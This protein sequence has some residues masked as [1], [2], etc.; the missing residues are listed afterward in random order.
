MIFPLI[1]PWGHEFED[2]EPVSR[3]DKKIEN[4]KQPQKEAKEEIMPSDG[5]ELLNRKETCMVKV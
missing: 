1:F 3:E 4:A 5:V 2:N